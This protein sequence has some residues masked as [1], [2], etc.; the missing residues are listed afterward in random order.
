MLYQHPLAT[1]LDKLVHK[2]AQII[3]DKTTNVETEEFASVSG[4]E[5]E[6]DVRWR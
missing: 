5:F 2:H 1:S 4:A 6:A 3:E